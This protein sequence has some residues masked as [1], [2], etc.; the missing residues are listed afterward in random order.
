[1]V[2]VDDLERLRAKAAGPSREAKAKPKQQNP[3]E[4]EPTRAVP[5]EEAGALWFVIIKGTQEGPYDTTALRSRITAGDVGPRTYAWKYGMTDW[6]RASEVPEIAAVL[7]AVP[8][9]R[10]ASKKTTVQPPPP[11]PLG[12]SVTASQ[13]L[14]ASEVQRAVGAAAQPSSAAPLPTRK[15]TAELNARELF[16]D[17]DLSK[18]TKN[19]LLQQPLEIPNDP[20]EDT[21][22]AGSPPEGSLLATDVR[23]AHRPGAIEE[24]GRRGGGLRVVLA[25][26]L[27][28]AAVLL[29]LFGAARAGLLPDSVAAIVGRGPSRPADAPK[30]ALPGKPGARD[31]GAPE[32][33]APEAAAPGAEEPAPDAGP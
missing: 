16:A 31:A 8:Q 10:P 4:N 25:V 21:T 1:M 22:G 3:W 9:G 11:E 18:I 14:D 26:V 15:S 6:K 2:A 23:T 30:R 7:K 28:L 33:A 12:V 17:L 29:G 5:P 32:A 24:E 27:V 13:I 20:L 19:P